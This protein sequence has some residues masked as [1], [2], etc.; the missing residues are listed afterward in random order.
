MSKQKESHKYLITL[1]A[2]VDE[3]LG[4]DNADPDQLPDIVVSFCIVI[5]RL[6]K[7]KLYKKNPVLA[8]EISKMKEDSALSAIVL[9]KDSDIETIQIRQVLE[10]I[11]I[12]FKRAFTEDELLAL[13]DLYSVRND[14]IHSYKADS[15]IALNYEDVI[16]KMGTVWEKM[17]P[18]A[19]ALLGKG[20]I[21]RSKPKKKYSEEELEQ[22]LI[23]EVKEKIKSQRVF[24]RTFL[25]DTTYETAI[26][27]VDAGW[28]GAWGLVEK[29]PR[30]SSYG[31][32]FERSKRDLFSTS[33][34]R[35]F[36]QVLEEGS[37]QLFSGLYK[38]T[39]CHLELTAKEYEIAKRLLRGE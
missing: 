11:K 9:K 16:K 18:I 12:V 32:S 25:N 5:E 21:K 4:D 27:R 38:C 36:N 33:A 10:R 1:Y 23:D 20:A 6:L 7:I 8:F 22:V 37:D 29:C 35:A 14:F 15:K 17:G 2:R 19:T 3:Y 13:V 26:S 31:F 28:G 39:Q 24:G 30:C 34:Y